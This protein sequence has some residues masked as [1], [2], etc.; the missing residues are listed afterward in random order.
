MSREA[1]AA[2]EKIVGEQG[3]VDPAAEDRGEERDQT[4]VEG[5]PVRAAS[6]VDG[7]SPGVGVVRGLGDP[8]DMLAIVGHSTGQQVI[9]V[10]RHRKYTTLAIPS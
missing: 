9:R 7:Y 5:V 3:H 8:E 4:A 6:F 1:D 10:V 2:V